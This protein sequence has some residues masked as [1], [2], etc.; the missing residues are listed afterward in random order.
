MVLI[1]KVIKFLEENIND[2]FKRMYL[3]S[4][5]KILSCPR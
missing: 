1:E 4:D 5:D 2:L 3:Y